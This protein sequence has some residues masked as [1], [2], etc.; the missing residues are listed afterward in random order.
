MAYTPGEVIR[1]ATAPK[2]TPP[3]A[4]LANGANNQRDVTAQ[5]GGYGSYLLNPD[6]QLLGQYV[7]SMPGVL[8]ARLNQN[9]QGGQA[10][11]A[12]RQ[13]LQQT[14]V[15]YGN[16]DAAKALGIAVDPQTAALA[17]ANPHS[18]LANL[19]FAANQSHEDM[20]AHLLATGQIHSSQLGYNLGNESFNNSADVAA[21]AQRAQGAISAAN[22]ANLTTQTGLAAGVTNAI[23]RAQGVVN[24][25]PNQYPLPGPIQQR[26]GGTVGLPKIPA[27]PT[28][29]VPTGPTAPTPFTPAAP[30][31]GGIQ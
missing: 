7:S 19:R 21:A 12:F 28:Y 31:A 24:A 16:T 11:D 26:V 2:F 4:T 14:L 3:A 5:S 17:G 25:H 18:E 29:K 15:N 22:Q 10:N 6:P 23:A 27:A 1:R 30:T 20:L 13:L 8:A 9:L